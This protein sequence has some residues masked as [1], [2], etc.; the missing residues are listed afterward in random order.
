MLGKVFLVDDHINAN[1]DISANIY[2]HHHCFPNSS[3]GNMIDSFV[4]NAQNSTVLGLFQ[5]FLLPIVL[6]AS[7]QS[8]FT[9]SYRP[10]NSTI[11]PWGCQENKL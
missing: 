3:P 1:D 10:I 8:I 7:I 4:V 6:R 5:Y 9:I 2:S 11:K